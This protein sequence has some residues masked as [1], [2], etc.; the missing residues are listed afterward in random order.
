MPEAFAVDGLE[1]YLSR[2]S[3][4]QTDFEQYKLAND[5]LFFECGEIRRGR[6]LAKEQSFSP[7]S[8]TVSAALRS[9]AWEVLDQTKRARSKFDDP[10][11]TGSMFA[12]GV[13]K[14]QIDAGTDR[15]TVHTSLDSISEPKKGSERAVLKLV[16]QLRGRASGAHC[17]APQF[18]GI[19][20]APAPE[21]S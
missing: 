5:Q 17:G 14:L 4:M 15:Y 6:H 1:L 21:N 11:G 13:L 2:A 18:Y 16:E 9:Q 12:S 19:I 20:Q 10:G 8:E 7:V 3:L